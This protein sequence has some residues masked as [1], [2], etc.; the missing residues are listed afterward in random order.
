[1]KPISKRM[2]YMILIFISAFILTFISIFTNS[3]TAVE[4]SAILMGSGLTL[5]FEEINH[6]ASGRSAI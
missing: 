2:K 4:A 5:L 1:M 3:E 6:P